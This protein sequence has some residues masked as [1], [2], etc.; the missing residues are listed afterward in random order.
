MANRNFLTDKAKINIIGV[1]LA[2][3]FFVG[4]GK[5]LD[6]TKNSDFIIM[7]SLVI[8]SFLSICYLIVGGLISLK[9]LIGQKTYNLTMNDFNYLSRINEEQRSR[10]MVYLVAR[11][12]ELNIKINFLL[13]NYISASF[14][15]IRNALIC[16]VI[17]FVFLSFIILGTKIPIPKNNVNLNTISSK[18]NIMIKEIN[19]LNKKISI[20]EKMTYEI[21][22]KIK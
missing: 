16:L 7:V 22:T 13:T 17:V 21:K 5:I 9:A 10:E 14:E 19:Q 4:F 2:I 18:Q 11:N 1:T 3:T 6:D 20:I 12:D 15:S 8:F